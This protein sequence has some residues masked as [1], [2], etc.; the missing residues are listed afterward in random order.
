MQLGASC[1]KRRDLIRA[2][3]SRRQRR[4]HE[5]GSWAV[6][7][8]ATNGTSRGVI[9][10]PQPEETIPA[11]SVTESHR[12]PMREAVREAGILPA[13]V[14][15]LPPGP[16][17]HQHRTGSTAPPL[18]QSFTLRSWQPGDRS[19]SC[20]LPTCCHRR[21]ASC[22]TGGYTVAGRDQAHGSYAGRNPRNFSPRSSTRS[23]VSRTRTSSLTSPSPKTS[24][25]TL[26]RWSRSSSQ[27]RSAST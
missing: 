22:Q 15:A 17:L 5:E 6:P 21:S 7:S 20:V 4:R 25:L 1:T 13:P 27:P 24:M 26:S 3:L 18:P 19:E 8:A 2:G 16:D 9:Q 23:P 11:G 14:P 10:T 12:Q